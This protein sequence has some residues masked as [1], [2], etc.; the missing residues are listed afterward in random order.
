MGGKR[1]T[2]EQIIGILREADAGKTIAT[3]IN[4]AARVINVWSELRLRKRIG[5]IGANRRAL[6]DNY[7]AMNN[8][9]NFPIGFIFKYS[10]DFCSFLLR[11]RSLIS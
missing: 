3:K 8:G 2:E 4:S 6:G 10:T 7:C 1:F 9:W 5:Q 11:S